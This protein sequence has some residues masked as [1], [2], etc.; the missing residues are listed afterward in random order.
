PSLSPHPTHIRSLVPD[1][2]MPLDRIQPLD[3][4][5]TVEPAR[6]GIE[7]KYSERHLF[8]EVT[9]DAMRR[10]GSVLLTDDHA[11]AVHQPFRAGQRFDFHAFHIELDHHRRSEGTR[12]NSS[13]VK[14]SYAVF[15]LKKK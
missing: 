10:V 4:V 13:H 12:L 14:I 3:S 7:H 6:P 9:R 1:P 5:E 2:R 8:E 11:I 15:C